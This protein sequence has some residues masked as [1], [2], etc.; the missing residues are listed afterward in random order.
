MMCLAYQ[1]LPIWGPSSGLSSTHI[2]LGRPYA[3]LQS[4]LLPL[5]RIQFSHVVSM[6]V[7]AP[8]CTPTA[9]CIP[10][11]KAQHPRSHPNP[12]P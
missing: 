12:K 4:L 1:R 5:C 9:A 7:L 6:L 3:P 10:R 11:Y 2:C 8:V